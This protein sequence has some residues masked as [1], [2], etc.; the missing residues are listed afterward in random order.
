[1]YDSRHTSSGLDIKAGLGTGFPGGLSGGS[2]STSSSNLL[3]TSANANTYVLMSSGYSRTIGFITVKIGY[4]FSS[5]NI[6]YVGY[7]SYS[8]YGSSGQ[9]G[10]PS[11]SQMI[12]GDLVT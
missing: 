8:G 5:T 3:Y 9:G 7:Y 6:Y 12:I 4:L 2:P 1:M 10:I 11:S